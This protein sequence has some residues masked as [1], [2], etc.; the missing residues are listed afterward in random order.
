MYSISIQSLSARKR[1][2]GRPRAIL[3]RGFYILSFFRQAAR[4]AFFAFLYAPF[5]P[6]DLP[7]AAL[8]NKGRACEHMLTRVLLKKGDYA[9]MNYHFT[10]TKALIEKAGS[11]SP[12][13][14]C[15]R[16]VK[17]SGSIRYTGKGRRPLP[18]ALLIHAACFLALMTNVR[19][20]ILALFTRL[21]SSASRST[22]SSSVSSSI[23]SMTKPASARAF[24]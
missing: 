22:S 9:P 2:N 14:T 5:C 11:R 3:L 15:G 16:W 12:L 8:A 24:T 13:K 19:G 21:L 23:R 18:E 4:L 10:T 17:F 7:A 1:K 6:D 20:S